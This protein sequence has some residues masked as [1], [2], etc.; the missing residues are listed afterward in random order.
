MLSILNITA[1][2]FLLVGL[3]FFAVRFGWMQQN[4]MQGLGAF[5]INFALPALIFSALA[6]K[7]LRE[8]MIPS[9]LLAY[10]LGS[11]LS[12]VVG[13]WFSRHV[14]H[15][16][17]VTASLSGFGQSISNSGFI[18][19]SV[20]SMLIGEAAG[21]FLALN[22]IVEN[23]LIIPL[24]LIM[25]ALGG[26]HSQSWRQTVW[27]IV[28]TLLR[29]PMVM[30]L[31]L[32]L[33]VSFTGLSVPVAINRVITMLAQAS[34]PVAL[35]VI[36]GSLF[37]VRLGNNRIDMLQLSLG[38]LLLHPLLILLVFLLLPE[39]NVTSVLASVLLATTPMASIFPI[40]GQRYGQQQRCA[41][42]LLCTTLLSFFSMSAVLMVWHMWFASTLPH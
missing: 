27:H 30:A 9:Y 4:H 5:V 41:A 26:Q 40:M 8:I 35:F 6:A 28:A 22:V 20:L 42:I 33:F 2:I 11:L 7:P 39:S 29:N 12:F 32:G 37:G 14:R 10:G 17:W 24:L 21:V 3:G 19:Y 18:G 31:V 36:G 34:A 38:K 16:D 13:F 1:P 23:L 25:V 15:A